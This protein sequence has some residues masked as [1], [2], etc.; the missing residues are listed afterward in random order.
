MFWRSDWKGVDGIARVCRESAAVAL[1]VSWA[2]VLG[3]PCKRAG[4]FPVIAYW[5]V[6]TS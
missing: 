5:R 1:G 6:V 4:R 2:R 3:S